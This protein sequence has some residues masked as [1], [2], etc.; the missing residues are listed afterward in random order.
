MAKAV[1]PSVIEVDANVGVARV[2]SGFRACRLAE[3]LSWDWQAARTKL[4]PQAA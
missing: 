1:N 3:L 4:R 2:G